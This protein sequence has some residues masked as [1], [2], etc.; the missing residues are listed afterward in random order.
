M[1]LR[2]LIFR[3]RKLLKHFAISITQNMHTKTN[4]KALLSHGNHAMLRLIYTTSS[5]LHLL[6]R[7]N[8]N[9][10]KLHDRVHQRHGQT[11][12][13]TDTGLKIIVLLFCNCTEVKSA[14]T[15]CLYK[16]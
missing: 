5:L 12:A 7:N 16:V 2:V 3:T 15:K 6:S 4:K 13:Q 8:S 1:K 14:T 9:N 11:D 10:S